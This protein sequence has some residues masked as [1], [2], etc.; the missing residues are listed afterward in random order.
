M[1]DNPEGKV[2][3]DCEGTG[4]NKSRA[5]R[6]RITTGATNTDVCVGCGGTG[7]LRPVKIERKE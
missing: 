6:G 3:P 5:V 2:C 1:T 4:R 7:R